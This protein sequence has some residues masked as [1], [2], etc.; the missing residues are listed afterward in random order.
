M[1]VGGVDSHSDVIAMCDV[2][3]DSVVLACCLLH[4]LAERESDAI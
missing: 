1:A 2:M 3:V 4:L